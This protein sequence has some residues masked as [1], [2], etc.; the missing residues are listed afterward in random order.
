MIRT[1]SFHFNLRRLQIATLLVLLTH[2]I[3]FADGEDDT[4]RGI[5]GTGFTPDIIITENIMATLFS[6]DRGIGGT[7]VVGTIDDFG[8]IWVNDLEVEY[9][10]DT[11]I[12]IDGNAANATQLRLGQQVQAQIELRDGK[13]Y[14]SNI[15]IQHEVIAQVES[16]DLQANTLTVMGQ[17]I[18]VDSSTHGDWQTLEVGDVVAVS[19]YRQVDEQILAT[20][21]AKRSTDQ[22]WLLRGELHQHGDELYIGQFPVSTDIAN[23][24]PGERIS[25]SG[26]MSHDSVKVSHVQVE[27]SI[28]FDGKVER[29]LIEGR[30]QDSSHYRYSGGLIDRNV[31]ENSHTTKLKDRSIIDIRQ[32]G[33]GKRSPGNGNNPSDQTQDENQQ[34]D[35]SSSSTTTTDSTDKHKGSSSSTNSKSDKS[36]NTNDSDGKDSDKKSSHSNTRSSKTKTE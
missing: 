14:A 12:Q 31:I 22:Q 16:L 23:A 28:P 3:A 35:Q 25:L 9:D 6:D 19:G 7:G 4:D 17:Q 1:N 30:W 29:L 36:D 24:Q 32:Q 5:G 26:Q 8:S 11:Q 10:A 27:N 15:T 2:G 21:I 13:V 34:D 33:T 20:D 18:T